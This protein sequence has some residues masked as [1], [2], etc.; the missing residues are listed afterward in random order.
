MSTSTYEVFNILSKVCWAGGRHKSIGAYNIIYIFDIEGMSKLI[1]EMPLYVCE[2]GWMPCRKGVWKFVSLTGV[3][4]ELP[5]VRRD[6]HHGDLLCLL[7]LWAFYFAVCLMRQTFRIALEF[8]ADEW[9]LW[10]SLNFHWRTNVFGNVR[11]TTGPLESV[12]VG[13]DWF[14]Y[15]FVE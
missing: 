8:I 3:R 1:L 11:S 4:S 14:W 10:L 13:F 5:L 9:F 2:V 7:W 12:S 15:S 6:I